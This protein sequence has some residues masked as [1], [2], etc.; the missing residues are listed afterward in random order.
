MQVNFM[1]VMG[2]GGVGLYEL[3]NGQHMDGLKLRV[4]TR[5]LFELELESG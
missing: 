3:E 2:C 5:T 4:E 1:L